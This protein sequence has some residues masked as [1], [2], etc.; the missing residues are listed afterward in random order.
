MTSPQSLLLKNS[1]SGEVPPGRHVLHAPLPCRPQP[2]KGSA[3]SLPWSSPPLSGLMMSPSPKATMAPFSL[4]TAESLRPGLVSVWHKQGAPKLNTTEQ[5]VLF[6]LRS[7]PEHADAQT[8]TL[9][10]KEKPACWTERIS[11]EGPRDVNEGP[12]DL[13]DRGKSTSN[14]SPKEYSPAALADPEP[15]QNSPNGH[16]KTES[17]AHRDI[18]PSISPNSPLQE[19]EEEPAA[20]CKSQVR[21]GGK[22]SG[23]R[24]CWR[25]TGELRSCGSRGAGSRRRSMGRRSRAVT[26]RCRSSPSPYIQVKRS[27]CSRVSEIKEGT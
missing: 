13:S 21:A 9:R 11:A 15:T 7:L 12:L 8:N 26:R 25:S 24:F 22:N 2:I 3:V 20:D 19:Q 4:A 6:R 14:Q 5:T 16:L 1:T 23:E 10:K 27:A 18:S 17:S